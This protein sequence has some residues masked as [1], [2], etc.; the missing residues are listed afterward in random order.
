M[1]VKLKQRLT[2]KVSGPVNE[3]RDILSDPEKVKALLTP[4]DG[5]DMPFGRYPEIDMLI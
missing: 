5:V 2:G 1:S 4:D 3:I